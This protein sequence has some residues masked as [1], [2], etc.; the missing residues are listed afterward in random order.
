MGKTNENTKLK[1]Y[2]SENDVHHEKIVNIASTLLPNKQIGIF[3][4]L[5]EFAVAIQKIY[6]DCEII[7]IL[8]RNRDELVQVLKQE[9]NL[10]ELSTILILPDSDSYTLHQALKLYP[11]YLSYI[12][13]DYQDIF[14]VLEKMISKIENRI[15][16]ENSGRSNW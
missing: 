8:V 13:N 12:Q 4:N 14:F 6:L 10:K 9:A 16:G 1:F 3:T 7:V 11:R 5:K 15:K 2:S